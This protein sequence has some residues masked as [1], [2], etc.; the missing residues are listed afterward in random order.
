MTQN[1]KPERWWRYVRK[2]RIVCANGHHFPEDQRFPEHGFIR[3]NKHLGAHRAGGSQSPACGRWIFLL[4]VRT[5]GAMIFDVQL[6]EIS[7]ME[8]EELTTPHDI[9]DYLIGER[10]AKIALKGTPFG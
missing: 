2:R 1:G 3:C 4:A 8:R 5:G 7:E 6:S 9:L 10:A